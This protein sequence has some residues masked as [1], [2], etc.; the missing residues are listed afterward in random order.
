LVVGANKGNPAMVGTG[1]EAV[2]RAEA[3]GVFAVSRHPMMWGFAIWAVSHILISPTPRTIVTAGTMGA[4]GLLGSHL[5]DRKKEALLGAA[6]KEWESRTSFVPR[7]GK[8]AGIAPAIWA[9]A[10]VLWL[11]LSWLHV[12]LAYVPAGIWRWL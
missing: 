8:L 9:I 1:A 3:R 2:S 12:W 6:W 4:L 5:Q 11:V 10:L 7:L